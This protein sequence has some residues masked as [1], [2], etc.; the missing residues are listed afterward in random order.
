MKNFKMKISKF[1]IPA[2]AVGFI[3]T[4][5]SDFLD[6]QPLSEG[7][8][9]IMYQNPEQFRQAAN[10]LY[11]FSG[12]F[13]SQFDGN[14]DVSGVGSN[15]GGTAP[16]SNGG[17]NGTMGSLRRDNELLEA[18]ARYPGNPNDIAESVGV[19]YFFRAW[20]HFNMLTAFGGVPIVDHV[21]DVT[22]PV[23]YGKRNSRY[24]VANI[25]INDLKAAVERLPQRRNMMGM[26]RRG[27][28]TR[29]AAQAF[30]ARVALYE[31]TWEKYVPGIGFDLD[32]NGEGSGA[33]TAKPEGYPSVQQLFEIA[34]DNAKAVITEAETG[35][36]EL[37]DGCADTGLSYYYLFNLD[38]T[39][40]NICNYKGLG[41]DT[42]K[43]F[44]LNN[45]FD[46]NL[47]RGNINLGH[48]VP[49]WQA[50]TISA[51]FGETFLCSNGLPTT[52]SYDGSTVQFN[53]VFKGYGEQSGDFMDE[54]QNRDMRFV[55]CTWLPDRPSWGSDEAYNLRPTGNGEPYPTPVY[56]QNDK[57]LD[58]NDPAYSSKAGVFRPF[59]GADDTAGAYGS[60]KYMP[61]GSRSER[62]ESPDQ[63]LIRL[64]EVHCIYAEA[65]CELGNGSISDND[66]N[67]SIN[68]NRKRAGVA[69]L[70][71]ALIANVY[72]AGWFNFETGHYELKKMNMLDEIR[73]ERT[74]E[75]FG[76]GFRL[77]DLKRWGIAH[78]NLKGRQLGRKVLGT[79]YTNP[80][81]TVNSMNQYFGEPCYNPSNRPLRYG[82]ASEDPS[83]LDYGRPI[84]TRVEFCL[85]RERDYLDPIPLDQIRLNPNLK[86][87]PGW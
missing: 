9:A 18:A 85:W 84:T 14:L 83:S 4:S 59:I 37:W 80:N 15:G 49:C 7:T 81:N 41:K 79:A 87:N 26:D 24:E 10:A 2:L 82:F 68:K 6:K 8:S 53:P 38:D 48:Q 62:Y 34:R 36:F 52:I 60:R 55:G 40:G 73:R 45:P 70:T 67:F 63:G 86:Q 65:V 69:P 23:V 20:N 25:I 44:I 61:E 47:R 28:L 76:E 56:P 43:E 77:N 78:I 51:W 39:D 46:Y 3:T 22:D 16:E 50:T 13:Q 71:N 57:V 12:S 11:C 32:G 1:I 5:C 21:L 35:T 17:W 54:F 31:A 33:G 75:L 42:N 19:A 64:A 58:P 66:L 74:C 30:L 72:D 27:E 29:E